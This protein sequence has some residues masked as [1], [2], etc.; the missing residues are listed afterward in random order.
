ME[1]FSFYQVRLSRSQNCGISAF[2][3][4]GRF[5]LGGQVWPDIHNSNQKSSNCNKEVAPKTCHFKQTICRLQKNLVFTQLFPFSSLNLWFTHVLSRKCRKWH[6]RVLVGSFSLKSRM[7]GRLDNS[8]AGAVITVSFH[9]TESWRH[10]FLF[11]FGWSESSG[12]SRDRPRSFQE[13]ENS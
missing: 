6:L 1:L 12:S 9:L 3:M 13:R 4:L 5:G 7:V 11:T 8:G 2:E 10:V